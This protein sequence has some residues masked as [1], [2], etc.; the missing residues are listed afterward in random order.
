MPGKHALLKLSLCR[1][2][3]GIKVSFVRKASYLQFM[4]VLLIRFVTEPYHTVVP[5]TGADVRFRGQTLTL[6]LA[7]YLT[8]GKSLTPTV[9]A[10][11]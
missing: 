11:S 2:L 9:E 10:A 4:C 7:A 1:F 8:L 6:S 5:G 3:T